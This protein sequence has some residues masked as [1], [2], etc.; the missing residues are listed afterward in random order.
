V[1]FLFEA[2][3]DPEFDARSSEIEE[4]IGQLAGWILTQQCT[5]SEKLAWGGFKSTENSTYYYSVDACRTIP[6]L[7]KAY[8]LSSNMDYLNAAKLAGGTF[9]F[10]MQQKP[11][12]LG[13]HDKYHGGF[14]RAVTEAD[15]WLQQ[16]DVECLYGLKAL[17]MLCES[18][19]DN[20]AKY[21]AMG[22]DAAGFLCRGLEGLYLHFD[23]LPN[24]DG[25]WH[26]TGEAEKVIFDDSLAYALLGL[27]DYEGW[28]AKVQNAYNSINGIGNSPLYPAY[29]PAICWAGYIDVVAKTPACDYYDA[30][31]AGIL[32]RI[33][34]DHDKTAYEFSQKIISKHAGE[35]MF[36]GAKQADYGLVE[37]K[38]AMATVC[39]IAKML[40]NYEAPVTRFTQIL[41]GRGENL[42][43][44]PLTE[45][46]EKTAY[47]EGVDVKAIVLPQKAEETLLEPGYVTNDYLVLHVFAPVRKGD[48][49]SRNG[50]DYE[51]LTVQEFTFKGDVAYRK[52]ACRRLLSQ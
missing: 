44:H 26:R 41:N 19:P 49:V 30:V 42:T 5:D 52:A 12:Q 24:G 17:K 33:R 13:V 40:L 15:A 48:K 27:Y 50:V 2:Y 43:L 45:A 6:A 32:S 35:F 28:S 4:K 25:S 20:K 16:M 22:A 23:P 31:T 21:E 3:F 9:L 34:R 29:N 11:S 47:G 14:A 46:G 51:I 7:L 1:D 39:W 8:E 18:D 37:N 38:Q 36:W 10:N